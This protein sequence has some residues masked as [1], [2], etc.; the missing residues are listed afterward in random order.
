M[1]GFTSPVHA[2]RFLHVHGVIQNLFRVG[3]HLAEVGSSSNVASTSFHRV[4]RGDS[5]LI[6]D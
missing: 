6:S 1:R 3:R 4:D 2:Q 5:S